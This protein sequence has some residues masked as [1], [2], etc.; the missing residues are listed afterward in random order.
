MTAGDDQSEN[1]TRSGADESTAGNTSQ[2]LRAAETLFDRAI[3][4][5]SITEDGVEAFWGSSQYGMPHVI[6]G[7]VGSL[8]LGP[9]LGRYIG[10]GEIGVAGEAGA[11]ELEV[12]PDDLRSGGSAVT[13]TAGLSWTFQAWQRDVVGG[14]STSNLTS[15]VTVT[16][17]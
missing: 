1:R 12:A 11:F 14:A 5:P 3:G 8:C 2:L 7:S 13:A 4:F 15:A 6:P 17:E 16:Y 10:P 9:N